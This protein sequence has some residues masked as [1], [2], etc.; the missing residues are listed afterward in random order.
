MQAGS[1]GHATMVVPHWS[2]VAPFF[3]FMQNKWQ[4]TNTRKEITLVR[5]IL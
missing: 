3:F 2:H 5:K 1:N 4:T